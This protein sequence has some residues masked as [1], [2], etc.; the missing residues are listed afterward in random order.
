[1]RTG[2][3]KIVM[4]LGAGPA[5]G[6]IMTTADLRQRMENFISQF[7][8]ENIERDDLISLFYRTLKDADLC[9]QYIADA[10]RDGN[11]DLAEFYRE[12]QAQDRLRVS[13]TEEFLSRHL[14]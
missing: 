1:V 10:E 13:R 7:Q 2:A 11:L 3:R 5:M 6:T 4:V 9:N 12:I 8:G 14:S